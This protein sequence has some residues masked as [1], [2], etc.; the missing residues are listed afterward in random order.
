MKEQ[1]IQNA[2]LDYL[3]IMNIFAFRL[4]TGGF[5]GTYKGKKWFV[6]SHNLGKGAADIFALVPY[7]EAADMHKSQT[8]F[9]I[10]VKNDKGQQSIEQKQ[11]QQYVE[12]LGHK[13]ILARSVDD[14]RD[15]WMER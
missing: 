3:K 2:I 10:E 1:Q 4:N 13:Y 6:R 7:A 15:L 14:I 9:W 5:S 12:G 8:A 11:F